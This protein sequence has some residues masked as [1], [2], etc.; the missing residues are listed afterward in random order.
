MT[1]D[2]VMRL[3]KQSK[4][5]PQAALQVLSERGVGFDLDEKTGKK[6]QRA[7]A[8]DALL[9]AIWQATPNGKA[10]MQAL[11][12]SPS[13][14]ELQAT[15]AEAIALQDIQNE[16]APDR[17]LR[18]VEAFEK[19][20]PNS[21]LLS[22]AYTE[23]ARAE[24]QAGALEEAEKYGRAS[25]KLDPDNTFSLII[26][27]L[28]LPEPKLLQATSDHG[29][30]QLKEAADDANRAL[31]LLEKLKKRPDETDEQ[32]A[33]RKGSLA[34]D[35]HFALGMQ[36]MQRDDFEKAIA[37]YQ[38]AISASSKPTF[39]YYYRMAEAYASVGRVSDAIQTL[40][41]A[42]EIARGTPMQK[43]ADDFI[44]ELQQRPH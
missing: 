10:H 33:A 19:K 27:A 37:D 36:E 14:V 16:A 21:S 3:V 38:A 34:A 8:D 1:L 12:T 13:G 4:S 17:R 9:A 43:Y 6:L 18:L 32:F 39:Q 7:G 42:S 20:F 35:A 5:D 28:V 25:L 2:E 11:L 41:K 26:M 22:Y 24:Q 31:T 44:A 30:A 23:A 29:N 40:Q 15:G